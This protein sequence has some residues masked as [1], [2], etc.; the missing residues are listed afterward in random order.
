MSDWRILCEAAVCETNPTVLKQLVHETEDAL[1]RRLLELSRDSAA[2][3][4]EACEIIEAA[5]TLRKIKT[6]RLDWPNPSSGQR[7]GV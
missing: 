2:P 3:K 6:E 4:E 7:I 5:D 1:F